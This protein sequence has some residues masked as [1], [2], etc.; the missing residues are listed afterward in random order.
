MVTA[1]LGIRLQRFFI[2]YTKTIDFTE[3]FFSWIP[4]LF[5]QGGL[6]QN[7]PTKELKNTIAAFEILS[8]GICVLNVDENSSCSY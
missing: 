5:W 2:V 7:G 6:C 3:L 1:C 4:L 8:H